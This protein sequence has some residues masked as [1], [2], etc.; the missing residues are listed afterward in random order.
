M[1]PSSISIQQ[2]KNKIY[3]LVLALCLLVNFS[4]AAIN[5]AVF[6]HHF[7]EVQK[8]L[9]QQD[10]LSGAFKQTRYIPLLSHPLVSYG[11]FTLSKKSGLHWIQKKPFS[12]TLTLTNNKIT[13]TIADNPPTIITKAEQPIVFS[14]TNIFLSLFNGNMALVENYFKCDFKS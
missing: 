6:T 7:T 4:N 12:S 3:L 2:M 11:H 1:L 10:N 5:N 13:Q 14:F 8:M 9:A